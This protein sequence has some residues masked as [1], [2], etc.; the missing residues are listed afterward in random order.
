VTGAVALAIVLVVA[1]VGI[2]MAMESQRSANS[3]RPAGRTSRPPTQQPRRARDRLRER[4]STEA[5]GTSAVPPLAAEAK[6]PDLKGPEL[7]RTGVTAEARVMSVVDERTLGPV[8]KSRL[9]LQ[10]APAEGGPFEVTIRHTFS[11]AE[12]RGKVK[13]G[14]MIPVRYD[15]DD[16]TKVVVDLPQGS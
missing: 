10:I 14:G 3:A 2:S 5:E 9:V 16:R 6:D 8:T 12:A 7:L 15:K 4:R 13:V 1:V 11:T